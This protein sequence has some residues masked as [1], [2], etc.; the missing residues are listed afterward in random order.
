LAEF[1]INHV[2]DRVNDREFEGGAEDG[3]GGGAEIL[4]WGWGLTALAEAEDGGSVVGK[5]EGEALEYEGQ[6]NIAE[7]GVCLNFVMIVKVET[8]R[9][10]GWFW[11]REEEA[12]A[13]GEISEAG[14]ERPAKED[15][16][17][18]KSE[19]FQLE[20]A[21][22]IGVWETEGEA[23]DE[24]LKKERRPVDEEG[25]EWEFDRIKEREGAE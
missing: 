1:W 13:E 17:T 3:R 6:E 25:R 22:L 4:L 21:G 14:S 20:G 10:R 15:S 18:E 12:Q 19:E 16:G 11:G 5:E 23:V 9:V 2:K 8:W 7:I 24:L